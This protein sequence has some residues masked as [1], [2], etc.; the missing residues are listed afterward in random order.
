MTLL[1]IVLQHY[2]YEL[3][4]PTTGSSCSLCERST[5]ADL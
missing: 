1:S 5:V 4:V 3:N 2:E